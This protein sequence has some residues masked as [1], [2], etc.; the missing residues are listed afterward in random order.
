MNAVLV[1]ELTYSSTFIEFMFVQFTV[2]G[3]KVLVGSRYRPPNTNFDPF[4]IDLAAM[5]N[6]TSILIC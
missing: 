4:I 1:V 6:M 5:K 2:A 3:T